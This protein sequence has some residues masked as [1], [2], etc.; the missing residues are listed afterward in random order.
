MGQGYG[1]VIGSYSSSQFI[2]TT[3]HQE[4]PSWNHELSQ[5][6]DKVLHAIINLHYY[7]F[8][9]RQFLSCDEQG[10]KRSASYPLIHSEALQLA[11]TEGMPIN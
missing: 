5:S 1:A 2:D 10:L 7:S 4:H 9:N 6:H 11:T 3:N 8:L